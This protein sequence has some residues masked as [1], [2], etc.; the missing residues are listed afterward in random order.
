MC[1]GWQ[2]CFWGREWLAVWCETRLRFKDHPWGC[3]LLQQKRKD[4]RNPKESKKERKKEKENW[5]VCQHTHGCASIKVNP[6]PFKR[7]NVFKTDEVGVRHSLSGIS[8]AG[9]VLLQWNGTGCWNAL[10]LKAQCLWSD[11][12]YTLPTSRYA[13]KAAAQH[14]TQLNLVPHFHINLMKHIQCFS[15][16]SILPSAPALCHKDGSF[17]KSVQSARGESCRL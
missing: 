8:F 3:F 13:K 6:L 16:T 7:S 11:I 14:E 15:F 2:L 12:G 1:L 5:S 17:P 9:I 10:L 4:E